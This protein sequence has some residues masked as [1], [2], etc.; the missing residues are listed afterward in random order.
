MQFVDKRIVLTKFWGNVAGSC[1]GIDF[2]NG[3]FQ[4][5]TQFGT[6]PITDVKYMP[7]L[8]VLRK[9]AVIFLGNQKR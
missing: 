4:G 5:V 1:K 9:K 2:V 6:A 3:R 8:Y 7:Y